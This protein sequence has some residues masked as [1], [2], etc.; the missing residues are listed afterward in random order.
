MG[1]VQNHVIQTEHEERGRGTWDEKVI[2][3]LDNMKK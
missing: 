2:A 3:I 1:V